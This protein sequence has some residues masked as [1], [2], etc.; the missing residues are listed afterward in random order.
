MS[1]KTQLEE[2]GVKL[3]ELAKEL[4]EAYANLYT[5]LQQEDQ[6]QESRHKSVQDRLAKIREWLE[7]SETADERIEAAAAT[8]SDADRLTRRVA[9][10]PV[11]AGWTVELEFDGL[12]CGDVI[13]RRVEGRPI[14]WRILRRVT[15][16]TGVWIDVYGGAGDNK[17][18]DRRIRSFHPETLGLL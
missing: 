18:G 12:K 2:R 10:W 16:P 17:T 1:L 11:Q 4:N 5:C 7:H 8:V 14:R 13:T 6:G 15:A 9:K 3:P